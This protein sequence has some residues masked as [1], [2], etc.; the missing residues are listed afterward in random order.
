MGVTSIRLQP[1]IENP[2]ESLAKKLDR[3]KNYLINQAIR[4]FIERK[5]ND[6]KRWSETMEAI[7]SVKAG[8]VVAEK[9]VNEW[10]ESW[11]SE[12]EVK[13]PKT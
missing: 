6:E 9:D 8:K 2:L 7:A 13:P 12:N 3:S 1:E 4:E 5:I 11:G 10:L